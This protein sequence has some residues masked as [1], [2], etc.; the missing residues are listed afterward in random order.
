MPAPSDW[1]RVRD[2]YC[3]NPGNVDDAPAIQAAINDFLSLQKQGTAGVLDFSVG[4][5]RI[6]QPLHFRQPDNSGLFGRIMGDGQ[7]LCRINVDAGVGRAV[8]FDDYWNGIIGGINL[9]GGYNGQHGG[10]GGDWGWCFCANHQDLGSANCVL[11]SLGSS[12]FSRGFVFGEDVPPY[13]AAAEMVLNLCNVQFCDIAF[14]FNQFNTMDFVFLRPGWL[15][16]N[17]G[18]QCTYGSVTQLFITGGA[19]TGTDVD[20]RFA[21]NTGTVDING[22]RSEGGTTAGQPP[23]ILG[24][25]NGD[26]VTI[27]NS[28]FRQT[29]EY[30]PTSILIDNG[31]GGYTFEHNQLVGCIRH[32][33]GTHYVKAHGNAIYIESG[34]PFD[35]D[36]GT[37]IGSIYLDSRANFCPSQVNGFW[38]DHWHA[39]AEG[40]CDGTMLHYGNYPP[41]GSGSGGGTGPQGP[42]GP[43]GPAGPPG[44]MGPPGPAGPAGADGQPG[45]P[46]PPGESGHFTVTVSGT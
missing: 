14:N 42:P 27:R 43:P 41:I 33:Q 2:D 23:V 8:Q 39:F 15:H 28:T 10:G 36:P 19:S 38:F 26:H 4:N 12:G 17:T 13:G 22:F 9:V 18:M 46:G 29:T 34:T 6:S 3:S 16:S 40:W 32:I 37:W 31:N 21:G 44:E 1:V 35:C 30:T 7:E 20:F 24:G 25:G 11:E 5:Y 45:S